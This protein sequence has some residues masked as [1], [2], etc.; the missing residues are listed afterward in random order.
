MKSLKVDHV[1]RVICILFTKNSQYGYQT[2]GTYGFALSDN[3]LTIFYQDRSKKFEISFSD[4][5]M[6]LSDNPESD[7]AIMRFKK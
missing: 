4:N 7:G 1:F 3:V 5:S 2:E 6:V